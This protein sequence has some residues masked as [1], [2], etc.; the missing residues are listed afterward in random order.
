MRSECW[1]VPG[2]ERWRYD[3]IIGWNAG[4]TGGMEEGWFAGTDT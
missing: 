1:E 4:C 2:I 3:G